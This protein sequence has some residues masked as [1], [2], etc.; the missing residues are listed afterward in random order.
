MPGLTR[1]AGIG[2]TGATV[3]AIRIMILAA[4][5]TFGGLLAEPR[6]IGTASCAGIFWVDSTGVSNHA[7]IFEN[8]A[9]ETEGAPARLQIAGEVRIMID[10][11]SRARVY[12]D[13]LV[14]EKGRVQLDSGKDYRIEARTIRVFL[15]KPGARAIVTAGVS[16]EVEVAALGATVRVANAEGVAVANVAAGRAVEL[17]LGQ[18]SEASVLTGCVVNEDGAY[19]LRDEVSAVTVEL[20]GQQV[21]NQVGQRV[22]VTGVMVPAR[23]ALAPAD[24]VMQARVIHALGTGCGARS[25][26]AVAMTGARARTAPQPSG[27]NGGT[28]GTTTA[29][30]GSAGTGGGGG[31]G[32]A[33]APARAAGTG[34][35]SG[36]A[37]AT[38]AAVGGAGISTAVIAGVAIVA[39]AAG[40]AAAVVA[41]QSH[42]AAPPISPGR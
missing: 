23:R 39:A 33:A 9:I 28:T 30:E 12:Q 41:T 26:D 6:Y 25:A 14:L 5:V 36:A 19:T 35:A 2:L 21:A 18:T 13:H 27:G 22:Q 7:T 10:A 40:T 1:C 16:G 29:N 20:R 38:G 34:G 31:A 37:A 4:A 24:Q 11:R 8:G 17:R 15:A 32:G 42:K 3:T